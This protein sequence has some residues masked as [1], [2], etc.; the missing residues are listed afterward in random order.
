MLLLILA[1]PRHNEQLIEHLLRH[2]ER[3]GSLWTVPRAR[4]AQRTSDLA[5]IHDR[6]PRAA[7]ALHHP[8]Y[9]Q[10]HLA[11][12]HD[13][14]ADGQPRVDATPITIVDPRRVVPL[15]LV[16]LVIA[17]GG[18]VRRWVRTPPFL[19]LGGFIFGEPKSRAPFYRSIGPFLEPPE[20][21]RC[22][23]RAPPFFSFFFFLFSF[24]D[25]RRSR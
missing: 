24:S 25:V 20:Y 15:H 1:H 7:R 6:V 5:E 19:L 14:L 22:S 23:Y 13:G 2:H 8:V 17:L 12:K 9:L 21:N 16:A 3:V 18:I 11:E 4:G 10:L